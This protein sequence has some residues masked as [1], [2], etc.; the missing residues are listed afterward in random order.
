MPGVSVVSLYD[1][2]TLVRVRVKKPNPC[3]TDTHSVVVDDLG[4]DGEVSCGRTVVDKNDSA[5]LDE[6]LEG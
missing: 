3:R 6:S 4:N 1:T 2:A 5:D